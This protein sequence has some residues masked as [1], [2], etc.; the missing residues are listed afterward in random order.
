MIIPWDSITT[1]FSVILG[2]GIAGA[3]SLWSAR[4]DRKKALAM[5]LADLLETRH[6]LVVFQTMIGE[7][8]EHFQVDDEQIFIIK[9]I[10]TQMFPQDSDLHERYSESVR[11]IAGVDP[12]LAYPANFIKLG[13]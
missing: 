8:K 1:I 6:R 10:M 5:A 11:V 4:K 2:A 12:I 9:N 13:S 7:L 3:G